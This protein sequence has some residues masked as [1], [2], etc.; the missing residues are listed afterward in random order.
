MAGI[1]KRPKHL[2]YCKTMLVSRNEPDLRRK[3]FEAATK[4]LEPEEHFEDLVADH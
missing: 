4:E 2:Q 1:F 3:C